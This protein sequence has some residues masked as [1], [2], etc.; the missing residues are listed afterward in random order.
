MQEMVETHHQALQNFVSRHPQSFSASV[1]KLEKA[2]ATSKLGDVDE[3]MINYEKPFTGHD[4]D[5][6]DLKWT[7]QPTPPR[8]Y[9]PH[10]KSSPSLRMDP[11][12]L[13]LNYLF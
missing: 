3:S 6:I 5:T 8:A 7:R 9:S 11:K 1:A 13:H 12:F 4:M 10:G 2:E